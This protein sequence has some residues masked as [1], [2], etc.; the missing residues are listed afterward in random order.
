MFW[1]QSAAVSTA[2]SSISARRA[3]SN[4]E[5]TDGRDVA[6]AH[7]ALLDRRILTSLILPWRAPMELARQG[8][9]HAPMI[10]ISPHV[11][12]SSDELAM[13]CAALRGV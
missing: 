9:V 11:D 2:A 3:T 7:R 10:R 6:A 5:A 1:T 8:R 13:L 4:V 12:F